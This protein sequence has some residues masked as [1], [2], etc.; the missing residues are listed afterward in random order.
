MARKLAAMAAALVAL[1][2]VP[3]GAGAIA[4]ASHSVSADIATNGNYIRVNASSAASPLGTF[5]I[6]LPGSPASVVGR[7]LC[8]R[9]SGNMAY[10]VYRDT[11]TGAVARRDGTAGG[12]IRLLDGTDADAQNNGRFNSARLGREVAAG[13]PIPTSGPAFHPLHA[14]DAGTITIS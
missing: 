3:T 10:V 9:V 12:Y 1:A 13:C 2:A 14:I 11:V 7:V 6:N 4:I 8:M 5:T